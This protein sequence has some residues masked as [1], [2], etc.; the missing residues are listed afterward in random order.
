M[1]DI[2]KAIQKINPNA[3]VVIRGTDINTCEIEWHEG[4]TPISKADIESKMAEL[5]AEYDNNQ[6]QKQIL[7]L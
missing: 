6:Y 1:T 5:Q 4:T 3:E 2:I 7:K